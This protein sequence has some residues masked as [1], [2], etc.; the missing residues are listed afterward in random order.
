MKSAAG[1]GDVVSKSELD[2]SG[3]KSVHH[4]ADSSQQ[5]E[6]DGQQPIAVQELDGA[7]VER[8]SRPTWLLLS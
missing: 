6:M 7:V 2:S 5:Y 3:V 8:T 1:D 4:E